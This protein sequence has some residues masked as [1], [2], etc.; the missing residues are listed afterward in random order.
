MPIGPT[1]T[2]R[3]NADYHQHKKHGSVLNCRED[4]ILLCTLFFIS[5]VLFINLASTK[6]NS[7]CRHLSEGTRK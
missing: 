7:A 1:S 6:L 5:D 3:A 4:L 2:F